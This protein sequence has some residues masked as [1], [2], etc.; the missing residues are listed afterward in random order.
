[1]RFGRQGAPLDG[2]LARA[3]LNLPDAPL[4]LLRD[5]RAV[6]EADSPVAD[7]FSALPGKPELVAQ[8][9]PQPTCQLSLSP[10][11]GD[12]VLYLEKP[13]LSG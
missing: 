4:P 12:A 1:M 13:H 2:A 10:E 6:L 11:K 9:V 8:L 3:F 5:R 7:V